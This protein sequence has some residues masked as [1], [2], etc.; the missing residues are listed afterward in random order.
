MAVIYQD[1]SRGPG[2]R[3][4]ADAISRALATD[5]GSPLQYRSQYLV[6][7][8]LHSLMPWELD[9]A[10]VS[11]AGYL[12]EVEI[13]V[14]AGDWRQDADK[15]KWRYAAHPAFARGWQLVKHFWYAAPL[16]LA[17]RWTTFSLPPW[18]GVYGLDSR[19]GPHRIQVLRPAA[20][21]PGHRRLLISER[22]QLAGA[23]AK[24]IWTGAHA[25]ADIDGGK[26]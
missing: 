3:W 17:R 15:N 26:A 23:A 24:R 25:G 22:A 16:A 14:S 1:K 21:R 8:R 9:L 10:A 7:A 4:T 18:A 2:P 11:H 6:V 5:W 12:T 19:P 13:K 20:A